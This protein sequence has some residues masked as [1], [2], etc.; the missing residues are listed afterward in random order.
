MK[1]VLR[2]LAL[3]LALLAPVSLLAMP[4][5]RAA[6]EDQARLVCLNIGK[7]DC[8]LL[9]YGDEA[10]LID[11]GYQQ[12]YAALE[13]M[14]AQYGITHLNGVILTHCHE[15]HEG[16]LEELAASD[17]E[18]D[19]WY[20]AALYYDVKDAKH[21]ARLAAAKRN[22]QVIWLEAGMTLPI[23]QTGSLEI[24]GPVRIN[25]ENENNN[26]LVMRFS[27]P[28]G[29]ILLA[30]DMKDEEELDLI[31][32]GVLKPSDVLKVGHHGDNK[33]ST[34]QFLRLVQPRVGII[35]T[36]TFEEP[37]TPSNAA[38]SR[39]RNAGCTV[40]ISQNMHDAIQVTLKEGA[41]SVDDITWGHVPAAPEGLA[42][43]LNM[44]QDM[45]VITNHGDDAVQ[46]SG[47][48]LYSSRGKD[49][50]FLPEFLLQPGESYRIGTRTTK[51]DYDLKWDKKRIW[52]ES[53]RDMAI[54]YDPYGRILSCTDNGF[55][56]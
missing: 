43:S 53:K 48:Q 47:M 32:A 9:L 34:Q 35:L 36:S 22:A 15:D 55:K 7:A 50:L 33:A 23:G 25:K 6:E 49:S 2:I 28:H 19:G 37:D 5:A 42:L 10:W 39:L 16:G 31:Q 44:A 24:L 51:A 18:V 27:S 11:A 38:L 30:G 52:H 29:S 1:N 4:S 17:I 14:L 56:E 45:A 41:I 54:L 12:T 20:A 26:S 46:L 21:P 8:L 3:L 13:T 40:F